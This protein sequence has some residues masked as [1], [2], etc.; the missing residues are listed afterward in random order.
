MTVLGHSEGGHWIVEALFVAP[1]VVF[2]FW[3]SIRTM[4]DRRREAREVTRARGP[5][6]RAPD[7]PA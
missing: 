6:G 7:P 2:V 1:V 5:E 4:G 3:I